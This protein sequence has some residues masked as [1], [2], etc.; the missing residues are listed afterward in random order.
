MLTALL[1]STGHLER[2]IQECRKLQDPGEEGFIK[3]GFTKGSARMETGESSASLVSQLQE[4]VDVDQ[5]QRRSQ[6][7]EDMKKQQDIRARE[8]DEK[9]QWLRQQGHQ[10]QAVTDDPIIKL[11]DAKRERLK[12]LLD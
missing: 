7:L 1:K 11:L 4:L 9:E 2:V 5:F 6:E 12:E 8:L 10:L 3:P